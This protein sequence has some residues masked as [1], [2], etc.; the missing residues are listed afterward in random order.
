MK[1]IR[2]APGYL[3]GVAGVDSQLTGSLTP[4]PVSWPLGGDM[5]DNV[6]HV[7][8]VQPARMIRLSRLVDIWPTLNP[9]HGRL[10]KHGTE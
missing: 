2:Q 9:V 1:N 4:S 8:E 6:G 10:D 7:R 5:P 3:A